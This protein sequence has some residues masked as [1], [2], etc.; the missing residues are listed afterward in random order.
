MTSNLQQLVS[1]YESHCDGDWEHN[2]GIQIH[3]ID[4]PG[5]RVS[6]NLLDTEL[7]QIPFQRIETDRSE[8]DWLRVWLAEEK[9]EA[10]CGVRN[11]DEVLGIFLEHARAGVGDP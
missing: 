5:W 3:T 11:L 6:I 1:W 10:A 2:D 7:E 4:N 8:R 9:F